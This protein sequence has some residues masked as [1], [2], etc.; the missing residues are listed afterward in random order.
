MGSVSRRSRREVTSRTP[1]G[2]PA[3]SS[4]TSSDSAPAVSRTWRTT[5]SM[6]N[7]LPSVSPASA[8]TNASE[9]GA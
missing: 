7:G 1:S 3:C 2:T 9:A 4:V 6:K 5:S 8:R